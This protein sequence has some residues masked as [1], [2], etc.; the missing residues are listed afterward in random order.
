[1]C[2][3]CEGD[4]NAGVGSGGGVV[5][6]SACMSSSG[7]LSSTCDVLEMSVVRIGFGALPI[8]WEQGECWTCGLCF[9]CGGCCCSPFSPCSFQFGSLA[10]R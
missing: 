7:V 4:G 10:S 5:A 9:G 8:L 3:W 1:M 2:V 6:V